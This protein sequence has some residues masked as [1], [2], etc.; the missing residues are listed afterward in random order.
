MSDEYDALVRNST[1]ELVPPNSSQ[2]VVGRKWVFRTKYL[3]DGSVDRFKALLVAKG[4]HQRSRVD[5]HDTSGQIIRPTT[6]R[7]VLSQAV[8][9]G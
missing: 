6:V 8:N 4:F 9:Y 5:F 3:P 1:W 2:N 7:I